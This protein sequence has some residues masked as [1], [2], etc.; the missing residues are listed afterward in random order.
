MCIRD[1]HRS[2]LA[3][4]AAPLDLR[5]KMMAVV[6]F[7]VRPDTKL[8]SSKDIKKRIL[9]SSGVDLGSLSQVSPPWVDHTELKK[10]MMI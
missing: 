4:R 3:A 2:D 7:M 10:E 1:S 9:I 6:I 8:R 5:L